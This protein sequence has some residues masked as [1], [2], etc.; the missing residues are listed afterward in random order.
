MYRIAKQIKQLWISY[1]CAPNRDYKN[2][3]RQ[4]FD[5]SIENQSHDLVRTTLFLK[6]LIE[7]ITDNVTQM[8]GGRGLWWKNTKSLWY[9]F[10]LNELCHIWTVIFNYL[11]RDYDFEN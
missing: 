2:Y 1:Y 11:S 7:E 4:D 6:Y 3:L 10:V 5:F 9:T 8:N